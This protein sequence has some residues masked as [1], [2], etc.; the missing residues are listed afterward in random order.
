MAKILYTVAKNPSGNLISAKDAEKGIHFLC[1]VCDKEV[2]LRKSGNTGKNAK[3][4][5][6]AHKSLTPNCTPETALHFLFKNKV[7][8][9]LED[10]IASNLAVPF[11]WKCK[12]CQETHSG[13][14]LKKIK[15]VRLEYSLT[16]C[17]PDLVLLDAEKKVFAVIEIVVTHK[18][19]TEVLSYYKKNNIV[20]IQINLAS[21]ED[22]N[23]FDEK[24]RNP[25]IVSICFNPKCATCG[26]Y[27]NKS[28]MMIIDGPCYKCGHTMKVAVKSEYYS[29]IGPDEFSSEE[30]EVAR[31][32]GAII[33]ERYSKTLR[34][35]YLV[36]VCKTC[37]SFAGDHYLF[38]DYAAPASY[39]DLPFVQIESGYHCPYCFEGD[40][41]GK[42]EKY[43]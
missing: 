42:E 36:N 31:K 23:N 41:D 12:H 18:P 34:E 14:L 7:F 39:G 3:R 28:T 27:V 30:I 13:N 16:E 32:H 22:L 8:K 29:T 10:K 5:H 9:Y 25:D 17:R 40:Y 15:E 43:I 11:S 26:H 37:N 6:F 4:P 24:F 1:P 33:Q 21:D 35:R 2:L 38:T 19:E 20:L